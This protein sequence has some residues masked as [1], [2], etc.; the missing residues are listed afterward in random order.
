M[1][2]VLQR[3]RD[4]V[5][6]DQWS[7]ESND[8]FER[9]AAGIDDAISKGESLD[10]ADRDLNYGIKLQHDRLARHGVTMKMDITP[11]GAWT[12]G[13]KLA[14]VDPRKEE[15]KNCFTIS[16]TLCRQAPL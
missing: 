11:R 13:F 10:V 7:N 16:D 12:E 9:F 4:K 3:N 6:A 1:N 5:M 14:D 2:I 15:Q 8:I